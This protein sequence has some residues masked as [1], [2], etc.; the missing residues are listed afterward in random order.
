MLGALLHTKLKA[1]DSI[2]VVCTCRMPELKNAMLKCSQ[3]SILYRIE[4]V[5]PLHSPA[6]HGTTGA[7]A[8]A[9]S[10]S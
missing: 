8:F 9:T 5:S 10:S 3:C 6:K 2:H 1:A 4:C 7:V